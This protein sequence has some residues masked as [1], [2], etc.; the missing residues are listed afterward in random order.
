[1][2]ALLLQANILAKC[3]ALQ[4]QGTLSYFFMFHD[5]IP[6]FIL[7]IFYLVLLKLAFIV[8]FGLSSE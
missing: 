8:N 6:S 1:M 3:K 4:E 2:Q 7:T 5:P